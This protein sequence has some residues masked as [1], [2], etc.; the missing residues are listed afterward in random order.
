MPEREDGRNLDVFASGVEEF[1]N[2]REFVPW[3]PRRT[4]GRDRSSQ[5]IQ[6]F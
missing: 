2:T 3:Q 1:E 6:G 4:Q 5:K